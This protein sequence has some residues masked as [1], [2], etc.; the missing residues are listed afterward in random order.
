MNLIVQDG[1]FWKKEKEGEKTFHLKDYKYAP[2]REDL[3]ENY[4]KNKEDLLRKTPKRFR[5]P[6]AEVKIKMV[7][8]IT[9]DDGFYYYFEVSSWRSSVTS[10][11]G[12]NNN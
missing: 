5:K 6:P 1:W 4:D 3:L 11:F 10:C 8:N 9:L 7:G 2:W 12:A